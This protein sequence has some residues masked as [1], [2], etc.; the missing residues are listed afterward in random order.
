MTCTVMAPS[1]TPHVMPREWSE[2]RPVLR[3]RVGPVQFSWA[4]GLEAAALGLSA[5]LIHSHGLWQ[6]PSLVAAAV[7]QRTAVPHVISPRGM[8]E[9]WALRRSRLKKWLCL[10]WFQSGALRQ[11]ACIVATSAQERAAVR[12]AGFDRQRIEVIP[13]GV[14]VP[15][16]PSR[17]WLGET[18]RKR[19]ALFVSRIHPKKGLMELIEAWHSVSPRDWELVIAGPDGGDYQ[20]GLE[21]R[22]EALGLRASVRLVG[23]VWGEEKQELFNGAEL[24]VLPSFSENFGLAIAEALASGVPVITTRFTPWAELEAHRCGWWIELN[25]QS[26]AQ[27][28]R[29]AVSSPA[30]RLCEMGLRGR[31][32]VQ[33]K[34]GWPAV[35]S[36]MSDLYQD[37]THCSADGP[38]A[39]AV[40]R[41]L[42][43]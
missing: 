3:R 17:P 6:H 29:E 35:A 32:L 24:F 27:A 8:L 28:L 39:G 20:R 26:L 7:A 31:K 41:N 22:I 4:P 9:P 25:A 42:P 33:D 36:A 38:P 18:N 21:R 30:D 12:A 37:L 15:A 43:A 23:S 40:S 10:R 19:K 5:H 1:P 13:N 16:V 34:Y 14:D 11:A 2:V